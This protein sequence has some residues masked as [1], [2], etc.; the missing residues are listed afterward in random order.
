LKRDLLEETYEA[1]EAIE[2]NDSFKLCEELGDMLL[3]VVFHAQIAAEQGEFTIDDV[4]TSICRKMIARHTHIFGSAVA[5][6]AQAVI[7]NWEKIKIAEKGLKNH[8]ENLRD[9]PVTFPALMRAQKV[10]KKAAR[11]GF[12]WPDVSGALQKLSEESGEVMEAM[13]SGGDVF[14]EIG[15]LFFTV[16]NIARFLKVDS[17]L[18][19]RAATE[20]FID[21]FSAVE[22]LAQQ[23][24]LD[25]TKMALDELDSLWEEVKNSKKA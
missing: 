3:Q 21:R 7:D 24:G 6:T 17:E 4:T 20:K 19:L 2:L 11:A 18:A 14:G 8:T 16:V 25:M 1:L 23:R 12:D 13:E 15:D 10:Q 22:R 5:E 9:V